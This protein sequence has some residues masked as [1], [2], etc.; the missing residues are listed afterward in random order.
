MTEKPSAR[1]LAE[2]RRAQWRCAMRGDARMLIVLGREFLGQA[3][4]APPPPTPEEIAAELRKLH[5]AAS[6]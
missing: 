5:D 6:R 2:L 4:D 1:M 3:G